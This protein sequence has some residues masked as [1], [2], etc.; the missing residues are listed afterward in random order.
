VD[1]AFAYILIAFVTLAVKVAFV[2]AGAISIFVV[3]FVSRDVYR[4]IK[5]RQRRNELH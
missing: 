5:E 3:L 2:I 1:F 4:M